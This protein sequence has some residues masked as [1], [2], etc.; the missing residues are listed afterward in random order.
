MDLLSYV[1]LRNIYR[2]T[3]VGRVA[4]ELTQNMARLPDVQARILV[5]RGDYDRVIAKVGKPWTG[6]EYRFMQHETS[7][8]QA[9][10][11][12]TNRPKAE[13]YW[14]D[15]EVVHCTAESYV[16]VRKARL[17]VSC[18]DAQHFEPGVHKL[19]PWLLRH[20]LKWKLLFDRLDREADMFHMI[21]EFA[22]ERTAHYFPTIASRLR[23][24]PNA[25]SESFFQPATEKGLQVLKQL[26]IEGRPFILAPGGLQ[27]RKNAELILDAWPRIHERNAELILVVINW[28]DPVYQE[29]ADALGASCVLGGFQEEEE[30]VALYR[31]AELV[32][33]PTRYDGFGMPVIEAMASGTPV[34]SSNTSGIPEVAGSA[35][36]LLSPD[37]PDEHI[38][39]I[40]GLLEDTAARED[41]TQRG[42]QR[43]QQYRWERSAESL[44]AHLRSL[45]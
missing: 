34:V 13:D 37:R 38:D 1:H 29:R 18:H 31:A 8:Q 23:V 36:L 40:C 10:W 9:I 12:L 43:A 42:M 30:L 39:A 11:F 6:F 2:S 22:A 4:R 16:P 7:R 25:A 44:A 3:G 14:P 19:S 35:A 15:V 27:H 20:R 32:W 24:V 41:M 33:F 28:T 45:L 5:D 17:A 21:S 26:G